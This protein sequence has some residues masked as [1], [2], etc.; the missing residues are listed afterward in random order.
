MTEIR[1]TR[2]K[3]LGEEIKNTSWALYLFPMDA[4]THYHK[5]GSFKQ[6]KFILLQ[7]LEP[8][9]RNQ[10]V[11]RVIL[12]LGALEENPALNSSDF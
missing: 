10:D 1:Q 6:W 9:V 2:E 3:G 8:A 4:V 12:S 5:C 11:G 7:F